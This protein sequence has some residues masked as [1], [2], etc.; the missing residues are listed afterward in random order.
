MN[1]TAEQRLKY[2]RRMQGRPGWISEEELQAELDALPDVSEKIA[3]AEDEPAEAQEAEPA[4]DR[5]APPP[6][7]EPA[8]GLGAPQLGFGQAPAPSAP[9]PGFGTPGDEDGWKD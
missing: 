5:F 4:A 3:S 1:L 2:D 7:V 6:A 8:P 9:A